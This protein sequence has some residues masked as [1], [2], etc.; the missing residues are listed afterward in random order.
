MWECN[1]VR[2]TWNNLN[3]ILLEKGLESE[4]I[5]C[6]DDIFKFEIS[7]ATAA[8]KLK[9]I[10]AFI[11]IDRQTNLTR[12][13]IT[14]IINDLVRKEKYIAIKNKEVKKFEFKWSFYLQPTIN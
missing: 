7:A 10:Q 13:R 9:I 2:N 3:I 6:Y 1:Q 8:I 11:Q 4:R 12:E 5:C 14:N